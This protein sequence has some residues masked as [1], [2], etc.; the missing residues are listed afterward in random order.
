MVDACGPC[1]IR[2]SLI[3][4]MRDHAPSRFVDDHEQAAKLLLTLPVAA[5]TPDY[6]ALVV[7]VGVGWCVGVFYYHLF[8]LQISVY[9]WGFSSSPSNVCCD[10]ARISLSIFIAISPFALIL[11]I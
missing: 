6:R 3:G 11:S 8:C 4:R 1:L 2:G 10:I 5:G 7:E 9:H